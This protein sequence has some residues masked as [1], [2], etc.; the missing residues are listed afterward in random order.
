TYPDKT[1]YPA[2]STV[3]KD[4]FN[5]MQVYGDACFF[6]L[7]REE[8]FHQEGRRYEVTPEGKLQLV[9]VVYNEMLGNYGDIDSIVGEWS[10]RSLFPDSPYRFDSGG[11]PESIPDLTY[12]EFKQFHESYYHPSNCL[13]FLYGNI[14]TER[15]LEF[16]ETNFLSSFE[17]RETKLTIQNQPRWSAPRSMKVSAPASDS[18]E[19]AAK[20]SITVNWLTCEVTD[21]KAVLSMEILTEMLLGNAGA[22]LQKAVVESR[23]GEDLSP[24]S[25]LETDVKELVFTV[26]VRGT[27][28]ERRQDFERLLEE[29]I[30]QLVANGIPADVAS[31]AIKRVE[32]RNREIPG[33][34]PFGLRLM[35]KTLRGWLHGTAPETTLEFSRWMK[36]VRDEAA[37][38]GYF[39]GLLRKHLLENP[40]RSTVIVEPDRSYASQ[41]QSELAAK[42]DTHLQEI[43]DEGR[44]QIEHN[45]AELKRFQDTPDSPE[46]VARIPSLALSDIPREIER[47]PRVDTNV[48][49]VPAHIHELFTNGIV[50]VDLAFD[51]SNAPPEDLAAMPMWT[52]C[53]TGLG[54]PGVPY[55]EVA[56]QLALKTGGVY[57]FLEASG[58]PADS[59]GF[60]S[61][62]FFR[63]KVLREDLEG[64]LEL[65]RRILLDSDF[66]DGRRI[67]DLL[68]EARNDLKSSVLPRGSSY[69][70]LR[71]GSRLSPV[72][73]Q[74]E[75]WGG[76]S[77]LLY[78][79]AL[80]RTKH[81][82]EE[83]AAS[84]RRLT[85]ALIARRGVTLNLTGQA[86]MMGD[87]V[88]AVTSF[89]QSLPAGASGS[90]A[91]SLSP[92]T[93]GDRSRLIE[94]FAIPSEVGYAATVLPASKL[95]STAHAPE[96]LL[97]HL[98]RTEYLW[99]KI[100]MRGGAYGAHASANGTEGLFT[101][102]SYRDPKVFTSLDVFREGLESAA[103]EK[104]DPV[105]LEKTIIAAVGRDLRPMSPAEKGMVSLRRYL[106]GISD[107]TRQGLRDAMLA[108]TPEDIMR[109]AARLSAGLTEASSALMAGKKTLN[110]GKKGRTDISPEVVLPL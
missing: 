20:S 81:P 62:L 48:A 57:S 10:Y 94:T 110:Q 28:P 30:G 64:G 36:E 35:G 16:I 22:P 90:R 76:T 98:L 59:E 17:P 88:S 26:G 33:G 89:T 41:K 65:L 55:D 97:A 11:E 105:V 56:R 83:L 78:L 43:G 103:R 79:D 72:L 84:F 8:I 21:P 44:K 107:E 51:L 85:G 95:T 49:G 47:I 58:K 14:P 63:L 50:Y 108:A 18:E 69:A 104:P 53:L 46:D 3:E 61:Y 96:V 38:G 74:E 101:F 67:R 2:S 54:F 27:S 100:R 93:K 91:G 60:A 82:E 19:G 87:I 102:S 77:Q 6:P 31:G 68:F 73:A 109:S 71:A 24:Q 92:G 12:E 25:G 29:Q 4:Y 40:H 1:I 7:L 52:K 5:L 66:G 9:G 34:A 32:F 23:I 86:E 106:Y 99:E 15:Q 45:S 42:L 70:A 13:I 39:E 75:T 37:K 80:A